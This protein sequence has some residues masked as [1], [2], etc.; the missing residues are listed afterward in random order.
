MP[1]VDLNELQ[2]AV[3][4]VSGDSLMN[5]AYICREFGHIY[6]IPD[7]L[8]SGDLGD[9]APDDVDDI[10]KYVLV[11]NIREL[12]LGSKLVF[13]FAAR[14]LADQYDEV[15]TLFRRKGAFGRFKVLL[16][17][18]NL[19]EEWYAFSEEQTRKALEDWCASEGLEV[20]R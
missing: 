4:W 10:G 20:E 14:Y 7:E 5:E 13:D 19:L 11:P 18:Q 16:H 9:D 6:W 8:E 2:G 17:Q 12:D 3:E 1:T 15:R